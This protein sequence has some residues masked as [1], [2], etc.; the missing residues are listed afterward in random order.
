MEGLEFWMSYEAEEHVYWGTARRWA[1][2][3]SKMLEFRM[4]KPS[5]KF[6]FIFGCSECSLLLVGFL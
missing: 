5:F 2:S 1:W 6:L 4:M 3:E